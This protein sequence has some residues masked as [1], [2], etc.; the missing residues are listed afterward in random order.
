MENAP[1]PQ[2]KNEVERVGGT[3]GIIVV[4]ALLA[5]GGIYFLLMQQQRMEQNQQELNAPANS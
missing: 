5:A 2:K 4:V 1:E 3:V